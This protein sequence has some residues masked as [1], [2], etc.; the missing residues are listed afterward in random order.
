MAYEDGIMDSF[1][2][3]FTFGYEFSNG[4]ENLNIKREFEN[5]TLA[6]EMDDIFCDLQ[7]PAREFEISDRRKKRK[8]AT[9]SKP[10][11]SRKV[12]R[13]IKEEIEETFEE[14]PGSR[15]WYAGCVEEND[16]CSIERVVAALETVP[17]MS[18]ELFLEACKLLEDEREAKMF[19]AMDATA[20]KKW[21][22]RKLSR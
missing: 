16:Y 10:S 20:R 22:L 11:C 3:L 4:G 8:L 6:A 2:E 5:D 12:Q 9:S 15:I 1:E 17:D 13:S 14:K 19:V 18:D 7:S 21:L